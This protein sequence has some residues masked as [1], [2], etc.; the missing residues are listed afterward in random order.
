FRAIAS[1]EMLRQD[2]FVEAFASQQIPLDLLIVDEA[3]YMRN[4]ETASY[5]LGETL[6]QPNGHINQATRYLAAGR[7]AQAR[8]ALR[9]VEVTPL[10][11]RFVGNPFYQDVV[12]KL[13]QE[14][15]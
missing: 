3:H 2:A 7:Q 8:Q 1:F 15:P 6:V 9:Q 10:R 12:T 13:G 5:G 14:L 11:E 4:E